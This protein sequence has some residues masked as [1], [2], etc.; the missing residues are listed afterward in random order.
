MKAIILAA[1]V[2]SRLRPLTANKPKCLVKV[3]GKSILDYQIGAFVSAGIKEIII[4]IGYEAEKVQR[5]CKKIKDIKI[6]LIRT[7][8]YENTN[9]M[10]S[11][12]LARDDLVGENFILVNGDVVFESE[13]LYKMVH[14]PFRDLIACDR[15][16]YNKESMKIKIVEDGYIRSIRKT[17]T[18]KSAHA[19]SI[20]LYKFSEKSSLVLF[21]EIIKIIEVEKNLRDWTEVVLDRLFQRKAL[22]IK[23]LDIDGKSWIE[24]DNYNDLACADKIFSRFD[25]TF[26]SKKL[27]FLDLD[28]TVYIGNKLIKGT[29][30]F[31]KYL[32][33][34]K[35]NYYFLSNNSS[36]SK[37]DYVK[38]LLD[39]GIQTCDG[40]IILSTDG[41]I[42]FLFKKKVKNV[43]VVGTKSMEKM[44]KE[45]EFNLD[46]Q[47]PEYIVLG[48][49]TELTYK[50]LKKT[51]ILLQNGVELIA[52]HFDIVCPTPEGLIPDI[53]SMIALIEKATKKKPMKIFGKPNVEMISHVI[54]RHTVSS[55]EVVIIGDRIYT[56]MELANRVDCDFVCVLSG[57]TLREGIEEL[58]KPPALVVK[59]IGHIV[60]GI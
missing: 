13:I 10:Y 11:L 51:A 2:G 33:D 7:P 17:I 32:K 58:N 43:Y 15:S 47:D 14:S 38:K 5:Y 59:D 20:D 22:K 21:Q 54:T 35:I 27:I 28:G 1:G 6:K 56:D 44:F 55:K 50:K 46:S 19:T 8:D 25:T 36:R 29:K 57:E 16:V 41:V 12:Y 31:L 3:A 49:D 48:Y 18:K 24:I 45:A 60:D 52:T 34:R 26:K 9:N 40:K 23:P 30:Q 42:E 39:L 37:M 4:I 53:G